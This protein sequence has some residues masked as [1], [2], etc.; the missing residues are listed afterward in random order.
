MFHIYD[1]LPC[2]LCAK[3]GFGGA[4][5][6]D[7]VNMNCPKLGDICTPY[8]FNVKAQQS[9]IPHTQSRDPHRSDVAVPQSLVNHSICIGQSFAVFVADDVGRF[10]NSLYFSLNSFCRAITILQLLFSLCFQPQGRGEKKRD[11]YFEMPWCVFWHLCWFQ[12]TEKMH[13]PKAQGDLYEGNMVLC[14]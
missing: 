5:V 14:S 1:V 3:P 2:I 6:L 12:L 4:D 11:C 13:I 8:L 7:I 10:Q 9:C